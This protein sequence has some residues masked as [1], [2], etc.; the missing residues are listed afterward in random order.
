[1]DFSKFLEFFPTVSLPITLREDTFQELSEAIPPLPAAMIEHYIMSEDEEDDGMT[2]YIPCLQLPD[3]EDFVGLIYWKASLL[4]YEYILKTYTKDGVGVID[5]RVIAGTTVNGTEIIQ[6][7]AMIAPDKSIYVASG[8]LNEDES[9]LDLSK[10]KT[11]VIEI[12]DDGT[13]E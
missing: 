11:N 13:L 8:L 9:D 7:V 6:S 4:S 12:N 2:E 5:S 3:C 10:N 1:M